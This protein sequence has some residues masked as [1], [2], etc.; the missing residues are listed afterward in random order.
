[1]DWDSVPTTWYCPFVL[2]P[3]TESKLLA[4][5]F[6]PHLGP[7]DSLPKGSLLLYDSP[8]R[9]LELLR[10]RESL[11][12]TESQLV[13]QYQ[14]LACM[15]GS[16]RLISCWCLSHLS[17]EEI[18]DSLTNPGE[19]LAPE[20]PGRWLL[21]TTERPSVSPLAAAVVLSLVHESTRLIDA[22]IHLDSVADRFGAAPDI[23]FLHRVREAANG[24]AL[25]ADWWRPCSDYYLT[26]LQLEQVEEELLTAFLVS[27]GQRAQLAFQH[28]LLRQLIALVRRNHSLLS[29]ILYS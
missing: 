15:A 19:L 6:R 20:L 7:V 13:E 12:P 4:A 14:R 24:A 3:S 9:V 22:Y 28:S 5:G 16:H 2:A 21:A 10:S 18:A 26:Q 17:P 29:R 23:S 11:P 27:Q 25:L 8:D 1:M